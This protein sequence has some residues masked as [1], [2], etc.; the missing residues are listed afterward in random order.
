VLA[1]GE[2][3]RERIR[4]QK[5]E[6]QPDCYTGYCG[7]AAVA[8]VQKGFPETVAQSAIYT[9]SDGVVDWRVCVTD[10]PAMNF[11]APGTHVGLVFNASVYTLIAN[12][13]H[14]SKSSQGKRP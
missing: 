4:R 9:K 1:A 10:D 13:L 7:C 12:R 6:Q 11:E 2:R 8:A 14:A 3:V 5:G